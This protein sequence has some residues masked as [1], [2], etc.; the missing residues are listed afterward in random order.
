MKTLLKILLF[1]VISISGNSYAKTKWSIE[2]KYQLSI[3]MII[4]NL[5]SN[6]SIIE[7]RSL[8]CGACAEFAIDGFIHLKKNYIDTGIINFELRP[9]PLNPLDVSAFKVL[10]CADEERLFDLDKVL[11]KSQKKWFVTEGAK[12]WEDAI[13]LSLPELLKQSSLFGITETDYKTC[14]LDT[15]IINL[16]NISLRSAKKYKID[17]TPSFLIN[18]DVYSGNL[19][20]DK[21]DEILEGYIN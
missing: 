9:L 13:N 20:I 11:Y 17:S 19:S 4:G 8:T 6:I 21:I 1:V 5:D 12:T 15:D 10:Y 14:N 7:Y 3:P 2:E 18:G 16:L